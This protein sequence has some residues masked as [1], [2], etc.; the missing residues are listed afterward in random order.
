MARKEEEEYLS[1]LGNRDKGRNKKAK[2]EGRG[3]C[4]PLESDLEQ[5]PSIFA[6]LKPAMEVEGSL[7]SETEF[8]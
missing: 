3:S 2:L 4:Q 8:Q 5:P 1:R 7:P 6:V